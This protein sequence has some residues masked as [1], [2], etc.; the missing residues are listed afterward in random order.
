[1]DSEA[2]GIVVIFD[3][4]LIPAE[5]TLLLHAFADHENAPYK[6]AF[7]FLTVSREYQAAPAASSAQ[8]REIERRIGADLDAHLSQTLG[9]DATK[10]LM[11]RIGNSVVFV[12]RGEEEARACG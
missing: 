6:R 1:M 9:G 3:V 5:A 11:A 8:Q 10:A 7:F 4:D 12:A 2:D